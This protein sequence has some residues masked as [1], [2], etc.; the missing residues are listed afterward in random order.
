M[1][2]YYSSAT[3]RSRSANRDELRFGI[4]VLAGVF[5]VCASVVLGL[6][7]GDMILNRS[8]TGTYNPFKQREILERVEEDYRRK[9][10]L[11]LG[12]NGLVDRNHDGRISFSERDEA[13]DRMGLDYRV[14]KP[15]VR[16]LEKAILSYGRSHGRN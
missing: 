12:K 13:W 16:D 5:Y 15:A 8:S 9:Y 11:V 4:N 6:E 10:D 2:D 3:T 1:T 7:L 14:E